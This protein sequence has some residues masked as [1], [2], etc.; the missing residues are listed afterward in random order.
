MTFDPNQPFTLTTGGEKPVSLNV[1]IAVGPVRPSPDPVAILSYAIRALVATIAAGRSKASS[2]D[3]KECAIEQLTLATAALAAVE[4]QALL[5]IV[6]LGLPAAARVHLRSLGDC[7]L[8]SRIFREDPSL[9]QNVYQSLVA[10]QRDLAKHLTDQS[11][12]TIARLDEQ[13]AMAVQDKTDLKLTNKI[14]EET[15]KTGKVMTKL[16]FAAWSKWSHADIVALAEVATRISAGAAERLIPAAADDGGG[17]HYILRATHFIMAILL[18]LRPIVDTDE[19]FDNLL[20][21]MA[22][23]ADGT[24]SATS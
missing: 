14:L 5:A 9:A 12:P 11:D 17:V 23:F 24:M 1:E 21:A 3:P 13:M 15:K 19:A 22:P 6:T 7:A 18:S 8:R 4:A 10:T 2:A 20:A 16:E